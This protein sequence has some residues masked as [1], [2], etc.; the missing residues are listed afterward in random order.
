M[1][2]RKALAERTEQ[3]RAEVAAKRGPSHPKTP[4][5][6]DLLSIEGACIRIG[7]SK[8]HGYQ[9]AKE[10]NFPGDAAIRIGKT[11]RVSVPKLERYLHGEVA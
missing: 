10:G 5:P 1:P 4:L 6:P 3:P 7:V 11:W 8:Q 9:L 2:T